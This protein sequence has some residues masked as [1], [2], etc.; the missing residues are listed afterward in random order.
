MCAVL[1]G[2]DRAG[3]PSS[4]ALLMRRARRARSRC[5]PLLV[6]AATFEINFFV[7][8]GVERIGRYIQVFY[9]ERA[10]AT[11]WETTA[12]NYGAKFPA[13][14]DPLFSIVVRRRRGAELSQL[15]R[16]GRATARL[17]RALA[18]RDISPSLTESS[19]RGRLPRRNARSI[20]IASATGQ[21]RY[22]SPSDWFRA[23]KLRTSWSSGHTRASTH[24][25]ASS[26][27]SSKMF[28]KVRIILTSSL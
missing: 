14:L 15:A 5:V 23:P 13:G 3:A 7:H 26:T 24:P 18:R 9:E 22:R 8:T 11:G 19:L 1:G 25:R 28:E 10:G 6:L 17:D 27:K 21:D 4:I 20:S 12:M 16:R 2:L